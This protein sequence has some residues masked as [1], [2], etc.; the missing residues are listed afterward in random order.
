MIGRSHQA[1]YLWQYRSSEAGWFWQYFVDLIY[2]LP[3]QTMDQVQENAL[4]LLPSIFPHMVSIVW[5]WRITPSLWNRMRRG[6]SFLYQRRAGSGDVWIH[7][8][9]VECVR[10]FWALRNVNFSKAWFLKSPQSHVLGQCRVLWSGSWCIWLRQ[11][12][13]LQESWAYPSLYAGGRRGKCACPRRASDS[14]KKWW[15]KR[16][17]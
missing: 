14:D 3:T 9:G 10:A 11:R 5:F 1:G 16:C 17:F 2:A 7:Y 12:C 4:R 13:S 15:K 8:S 6:A